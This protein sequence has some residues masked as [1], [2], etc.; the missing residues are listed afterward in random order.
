MP[1]IPPGRKRGKYN[2]QTLSKKLKTAPVGM[3]KPVAGPDA[4]HSNIAASQAKSLTHR[5]KTITLWK[6]N[7][8]NYDDEDHD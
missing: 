6:P 2:V 8:P 1:N 7:L 4:R 5:K 3:G